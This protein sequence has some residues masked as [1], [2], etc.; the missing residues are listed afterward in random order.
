M[1]AVLAAAALAALGGS[2]AARATA[3]RVQVGATASSQP[4]A[5]GFLGLALEYNEV[6]QL[7]GT[8]PSSV[9][10][11]FVALLHDL[12]PAGHAVLRIGG[13]STDR[14]WWPVPGMA[15]PLGITYNLTPGWTAD[16]RAL[17]QA[18]GAELIPGIELE[19]DNRS[20]AQLEASELLRRVGRKYIDA[21]EIGNEPELYRAI[22]W[23][24]LLGGRP[25]PWYSPSGTAAFNRPPSYGPRSFVSQLRAILRVMPRVP[26]AAPSVGSPPWL[27]AFGPLIGRL[28]RLG[29]VTWHA[30][31]LNQCVKD[32]RSPHYPSVP[33]LLSIA[34]SR[35]LTWGTNPYVARAHAAGAGF[36]IDELGSVSCNGRAGVSNTFAS[37]LWLLDALFN[38]AA[39]N[40]D[41]VNLHTYPGLPN[42]LFDFS[43]FGE[44]WKGAVHPLYYGAMMFAQ[45]APT[46]S[47]LLR[48]QAGRQTQLRAWATLAPDHRLRV[49]LIND[50]PRAGARVLLSAPAAVGAGSAASVERL[51]APSAY[52]TSGVTI[53]GRTFGAWT[54]SGHLQPLLL[55]SVAPVKGTYDV[56][57]PAASAALLTLPAS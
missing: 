9:N 21:L 45:A 3:F 31:G 29:I 51:L 44:R 42:N 27:A 46:G 30:Y 20:I 5:P 23:Y 41:G 22:A 43:R 32:P 15:R 16:A 37:A 6:P 2:A 36:R 49:L 54:G 53:G 48:V 39:Q 25:V 13:Q 40:I 19:A 17:A 14:S 26:V 35:R 1:I 8:S 50:S 33:N 56:S 24:K 11:V 10:P 4:L 34:A 28:A 52:A 7:A 38:V 57:L 12:D 47:Q 55:G 18:S